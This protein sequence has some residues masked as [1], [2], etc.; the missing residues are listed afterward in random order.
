MKKLTKIEP[1]P[2]ANDI[3]PILEWLS[4]SPSN[5]LGQHQVDG[6]IR[7]LIHKVNELTDEV[8]RM[9][10]NESGTVKEIDK[11]DLEKYFGISVK[12]KT[13]QL[14]TRFKPYMY[15]FKGSGMLSNNYDED[16]VIENAIECALINVEEIIRSHYT[17]TE[18]WKFYSEVKNELLKMKGGSNE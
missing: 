7:L 5:G 3:K 8:N 15:C 10:G 18:S 12:D 6:V 11:N 2:Q 17:N 14:I 1:Q 9:Q 16:R 13:I 4:E